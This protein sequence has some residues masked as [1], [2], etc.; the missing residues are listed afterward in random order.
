[1]PGSQEHT[2]GYVYYLNLYL[3]YDSKTAG[4]ILLRLLHPMV[5][6]R[7]SWVTE[8]NQLICKGHLS[9]TCQLI[10][11]YQG[12]TDPTMKIGMHIFSACTCYKCIHVSRVNYERPAFPLL[13][14]QSLPIQLQGLHVLYNTVM[15]TW[16]PY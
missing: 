1:M 6:V 7:T 8:K 3:K 14:L 5:C 12:H 4:H 2:L 16:H 13:V 10:T 11:K 9:Y 15:C